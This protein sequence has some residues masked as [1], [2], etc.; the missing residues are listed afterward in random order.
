MRRGPEARWRPSP[1]REP[2]VEMAGMATQVQEQVQETMKRESGLEL[3]THWWWR[4]ECT[5]ELPC[6]MLWIALH[7]YPIS[8]E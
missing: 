7:F 8:L 2:M 1:R 3:G 6:E 4:T 5:Y